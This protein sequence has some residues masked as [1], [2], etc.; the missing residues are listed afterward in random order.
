M[1]GF[2]RLSSWPCK[3]SD[4]VFYAG[5][6]AAFLETQN[7]VVSAKWNPFHAVLA[8]TGSFV[9]GDRMSHHRAFGMFNIF[10]PRGV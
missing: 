1:E 4:I 2:R 5:E 6:R 10:A 7:V 9:R 3:K 8:Y